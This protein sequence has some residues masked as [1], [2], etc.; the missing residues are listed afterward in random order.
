MVELN[1]YQSFHIK[2]YTVHS[3]IQKCESRH[4]KQNDNQ[5]IKK[6]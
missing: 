5:Y 2:K 6:I 4:V 3:Q 1:E